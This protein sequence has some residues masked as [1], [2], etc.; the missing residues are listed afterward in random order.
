M[1]LAVGRPLMLIAYGP[2]FQVTKLV[3]QM[4]GPK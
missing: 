2:A 3:N 4:T 1:R